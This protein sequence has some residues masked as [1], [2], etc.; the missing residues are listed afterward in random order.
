[1]QAK[2]NKRTMQR[3]VIIINEKDRL[4]GAH[5][6]CLSK[7]DSS[8]WLLSLALSPLT[9]FMKPGGLSQHAGNQ[10]LDHHLLC[11]YCPIQWLLPCRLPLSLDG[12]YLA[13]SAVDICHNRRNAQHI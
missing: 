10:G 7:P 5:P 3:R 13:H 11:T 1:M 6:S 4:G 2:V 8:P 12:N 9:T